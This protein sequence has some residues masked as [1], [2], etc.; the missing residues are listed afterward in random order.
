MN[1]LLFLL[2]STLY[3]SACAA[4]LPTSE[5][6]EQVRLAKQTALTTEMAAQNLELGAPS[7]IR[8]FKKEK[9]LETWIQDQETKRYVLFK[10]YPIC[11]YSGTFGPK[12]AEG[13]HQAPEGFY[14]IKANQMNPWSQYHLS[15]DIGFP[16]EYDRAHRRTGSNL[17]IHGDCKSEGCYAITDE[18]IEDVYLLTEASITNG[19][20][21]PV[22]AFPFRMTARNMERHNASQWTPFWENLKEGYDAFE[23]TKTPPQISVSS[24]HQ[25]RKY[26][27][28]TP[29]NKITLF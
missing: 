22:H 16:N 8:V 26:V 17:M 1:R 19:H 23:L 6:L 12:L 25:N 2:M 7:L 21:V 5:R 3:L 4:Q 9:T 18:S 20:N 10:S 28:K 11:N 13:D 24:G 29:D 15:F 14:T 27:F